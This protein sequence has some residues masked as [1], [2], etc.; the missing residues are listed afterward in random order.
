[1]TLKNLRGKFILSLLLGMI[2]VVGLMVYGDFSDIM[3]HVGDF[4]WELL[5][6]LL[7][8]SMCN[9]LIRFLKWHFYLH[10]IG[11]H[12]VPWTDS[13]MA[14]FSGLAMVITPGKFGEWLKSYLLQE[15]RGIPF[16]RTAPILLAER[17][18]D[19]VALLL[20]AVAGFIV[21]GEAWEVFVVVVVACVIA[22]VV[23]RHRPTMRAILHAAERAP[24]FSRFASRVEDF[25][26]TTYVL[27]EPWSL[28]L[29]TFLSFISWGGE[30]VAFY[31]VLTGLGYHGSGML[32]LKAAFILPISTLAG[33]VII[34]APGGLGVAETGI[35]GLLQVMISG[36]SKSVASLAALII[37]FTTLWFGVFV[38]LGVLAVT[39]RRISARAAEVAPAPS[40]PPLAELE[41]GDLSR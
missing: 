18:T 23:T 31:L 20:L 12:D 2:V 28:I 17:F 27:F 38:G 39:T 4:R 1:M 10:Q 22:M 41:E 13:F 30:V 6:L 15:M 26:E 14:F 35:T 16:L 25:Y 33:A 21:F 29:T 32:L 11:I 8:L 9:Y 3:G 36:M 37:R 7:A 5:P 19:S 34:I 40:A 24:V